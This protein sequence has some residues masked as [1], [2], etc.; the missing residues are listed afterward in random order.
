MTV[1]ARFAEIQVLP[2][3]PVNKKAAFAVECGWMSHRMDAFERTRAAAGVTM[4][5]VALL[6][7]PGLNFT[8][9]HR[10]GSI[11]FGEVAGIFR[12]S[13]DIFDIDM[14]ERGRV[15]HGLSLEE[16]VIHRVPLEIL[17]DY[18][19]AGEEREP[20]HAFAAPIVAG[21]KEKWRGFC[22][23]LA[24]PRREDF[25][26]FNEKN[27]FTVIRGALYAKGHGDFACFYVEGTSDTKSLPKA[28]A[29]GGDLGAWLARELHEIHGSDLRT[30]LP[31]TPVGI[32]WDWAVGARND[33]VAPISASFMALFKG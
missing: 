20:W 23:E 31:F 11:D 14:K 1:K 5:R 32:T 21:A 3:K 30:G 28:I 6:E 8:I 25:A 15:L 16:Q 12:N 4:E 7:T 22:R 26:R 18:S 19:A 9:A 33:P 27:G 29:A 24:G 13:T 17:I 2:V 10:E